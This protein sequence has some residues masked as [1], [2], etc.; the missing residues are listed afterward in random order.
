[1]AFGPNP[2]PIQAYICVKDGS[3]AIAF[4]E[5]AFGAVCTFKKMAE[6]GNR[7]MHANLD[8]FGSEIMLHDEFPEFGGILMSP[9]TRA[10]ASVG[11]HINLASPVDVDSAVN[12]ARDAGA[13]V[14]FGPEDIFWGARYG[15]VRDPSGHIWA[16]NAALEPS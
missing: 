5:R 4:Y 3:Q 14:V 13:A 9:V 10:G 2:P 12:R 7:V 16:F 1:M 11:I 15:Q 8:M 6:D